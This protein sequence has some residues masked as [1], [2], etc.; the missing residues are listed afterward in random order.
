M[1]VEADIYNALKSL[2]ANRVYRDVAPDSV[3]ALPRITFQQVGGQSVNFLETTAP[4]RKNA[5]FQVNAWGA[6]RD[7]VAVLSRQIENAMRVI[8]ATVLAA[9]VAVY[10]YETKLYGTHQDFSIWHTD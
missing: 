5:R 2:T 8:L 10:E 4:S 9:P 6:D 3:T 1:T 7:S